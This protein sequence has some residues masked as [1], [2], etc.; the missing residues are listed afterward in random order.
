M[1]LVL[2]TELK[3]YNLEEHAL[4]IIFLFGFTKIWTWVR[5][6]VAL[7]TIVI[8]FFTRHIRLYR[9]NNVEKYGIFW[10]QKLRQL[11]YLRTILSLFTLGVT[12]Y[13]VTT[14]IIDWNLV[15]SSF[16]NMQYL[17]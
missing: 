13:L 4:G 1:P 5:A 7:L 8:Y 15:F 9:D 14:E 2:A 17:P 12:L 6:I 10:I 3:S 16:K 11:S